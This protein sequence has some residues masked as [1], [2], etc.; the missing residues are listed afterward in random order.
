MVNQLPLETFGQACGDLTT[1]APIFA[2]DGNGTHFVDG[3]A[4][5][6]HA[7]SLL[8]LWYP[9]SMGMCFVSNT[10]SIHCLC[11]AANFCSSVSMDTLS[12]YC[13]VRTEIS[14]V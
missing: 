13:S 6:I 5:L 9:S 2:G 4:I 7:V 11:E 10:W 14:K 8:H 3:A 1:A 12:S